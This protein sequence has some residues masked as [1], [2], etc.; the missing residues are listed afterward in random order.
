MYFRKGSDGGKLPKK[1]GM[2]YTIVRSKVRQDF[3]PKLKMNILRMKNQKVRQSY[4][5]AIFITISAA[6][7]LKIL[8]NMH[9]KVY[10]KTGTKLLAK[11]Q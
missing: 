7:V 10:F 8:L 11:W 2:I 5:F 1:S 4:I 6:I 3:L 9:N